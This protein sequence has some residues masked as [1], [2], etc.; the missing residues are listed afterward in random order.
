MIEDRACGVGTDEPRLSG[1]RSRGTAASVVDLIGDTPLVRLN[2]VVPTG[3]GRVLAKLESLNPGGSV[4][5]RIAVAMIEE[6]ERDGRLRSGATIVEPTSGNTGI[7]LAMV[8]A[9]RGYR[10]I[11]TMPEDMSLER[12]QLLARLGAELHLTPAIEGMTGAVFAAQ[13]LLRSHPDYFMPQQFENPA[14]PDAHEQTT[15][16]EILEQTEGNVDAFVAGVGTGGT[17]TGVG[18]VLKRIRPETLVVAVEPA[19]SPVLQGGRARPHAIQGIGASFV[20]SVLD[21]S[22]I[23]RVVGVQ[24]HEATA[25]AAR[26][27]REEGLLVGISSGANVLVAGRVAVELGSSATVV[28]ILCD[29]GERYLSVE[30]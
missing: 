27:A 17:I 5:D 11:L 8:A 13:E 18:R 29:T 3:A 1:R 25:M 22:V 4:K 14:N 23:D 15:A 2:R 6:A 26:L 21:R 30:L 19:R 10:L 24:D 9:A 12:R 7:G 16:R 28:T 20:P